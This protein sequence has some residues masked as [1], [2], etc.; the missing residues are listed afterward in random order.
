MTTGAQSV[1]LVSVITPAYRAARFIEQ[2]I[3]SVRAQS[4]QNWEMLVVDD[5][6]PDGTADLVARLAEADPRV[7]L[8]RKPVQSG[9]SASRNLAIDAARGRWL[10]FLDSDDMWLPDK[11]ERQLAFAERSGG[12][13]LYGGFRR[14]SEDG[15]RVGRFVRVPARIDYHGLLTNTCIGTLTVMLDRERLPP[16]VF[17]DLRRGNDFAAWLLLLRAG[18][19][20]YG[21]NEDLGRYRTVSNSL[22]SR[23]VR[24]SSWVWRVYRETAGLDV[25][26]SLWCFSHYAVRG[27]MKRVM[28]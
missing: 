5:A 24:T 6:S 4:F 25:V 27:A 13:F 23:R 17:P 9:A 19:W 1:P 26:R 12:A 14:I 18:G 28:F 7:R 20:A 16:V 11:L 21:L 3:A 22:S 10:A 15:N 8:Y 2:T